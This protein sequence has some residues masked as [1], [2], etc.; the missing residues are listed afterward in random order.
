MN[1]KLKAEFLNTFLR[2]NRTRPGFLTSMG[3]S[4]GALAILEKLKT[5]GNVNGICETLHIT[6]PAVTYLLNSLE[7]DGYIVRSIDTADRRRIEI[8]LTDKSRETIRTSR[9]SHE[10]FINEVLRRFGE[11]NSR[12]FI[13]LLNRF[14]DIIDELKE[15]S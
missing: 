14:A 15:E 5:D 11:T 4:W 6:K 3:L 8:K 2:L 7:K 1:E 13:R 10:I 12:N 9:K